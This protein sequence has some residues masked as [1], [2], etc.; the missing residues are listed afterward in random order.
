MKL[1]EWIGEKIKG[2]E[3]DFHFRM[4]TIIYRLTENIAVKMEECKINRLELARRMEVSPAYIT[5]ILR[6][7]SNFTL[8]T[9]LKLADSLNQELILDFRDKKVVAQNVVSIRDYRVGY[10]DSA[11]S[12]LEPPMDPRIGRFADASTTQVA[13]WASE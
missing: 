3:K 7:N 9:L 12:F 6:G 13:G 2:F 4:E 8:K 1:H 5:K 11:S 10:T